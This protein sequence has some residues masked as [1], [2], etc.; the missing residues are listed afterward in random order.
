MRVVS[1]KQLYMTA[2]LR[3]WT[4]VTDK[5]SSIQAFPGVAVAELSTTSLSRQPTL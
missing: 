2:G 5:K 3:N 4:N 1:G